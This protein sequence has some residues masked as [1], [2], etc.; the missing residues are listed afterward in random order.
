VSTIA[1]LSLLPSTFGISPGF[2]YGA[3]KVR[4]VNL[5]GWLVLEARITSSSYVPTRLILSLITQPW[6]TPSIFDDTGDSRIIDEWTFC[7]YQSREAAKNKLIQ[8]WN[9][10]ITEADFAAIAAAG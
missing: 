8:H 7:Q 5:G 2:P 10:F 3:K 9:T 4:G 1:T 6:I